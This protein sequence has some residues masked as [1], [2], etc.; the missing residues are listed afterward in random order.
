MEP[1]YLAKL[2]PQEAPEEGEDFD[3]IMNDIDSKIMVSK[4][5]GQHSSEAMKQHISI[6]VQWRG[7]EKTE[8]RQ[9]KKARK[10]RKG[11]EVTKKEGDHNL[12]IFLLL[13]TLLHIHNPIL[14]LSPSS[15][16]SPTGSPQSSSAT[17]RPTR[18]CRASWGR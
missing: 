7:M 6:A 13:P 16:A 4:S 10:G 3:V 1:G 14:L 5:I 11:R 2:L 18:P 8:M 9:R 12:I 15:P 17:T